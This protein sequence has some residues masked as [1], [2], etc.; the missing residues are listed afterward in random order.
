[1]DTGQE[2]AFSYWLKSIQ[3]V[4]E[5]LK[6]MKLTPTLGDHGD[7]RKALLVSKN[8]TQVH[9]RYLLILT[10]DFDLD[11]CYNLDIRLWSAAICQEVPVQNNKCIF[12]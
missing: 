2:E 6:A 5:L 10:F 9:L 1:M 12:H 11:V 8:W 7:L 4:Q 3:I